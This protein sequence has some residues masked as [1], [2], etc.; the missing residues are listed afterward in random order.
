MNLLLQETCP[1]ESYRT[2]PL[3]RGKTAT[4][5]ASDYEWLNQWT[6]HAVCHGG[7]WYAERSG[8]RHGK[9]R[10]NPILM[11]RQI[12][13]LEQGDR[14]KVDHKEPSQSLDNRRKNL[15]IATTSQNAMN[16]R[17]KTTSKSKYKGIV[18]HKRDKR[19]QAQIVLNGKSIYLGG[20]PSPEAA[21]AAYQ[22]AAM[23]YFGEFARFE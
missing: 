6:W 20:F 9:T 16:K 8:P 19:W 18:W 10:D 17:R 14:K 1:E 5:D 2:I 12:L 13:G 21:H 11:H 15:R 23:Q 22:K 4:V 7:L 3:T